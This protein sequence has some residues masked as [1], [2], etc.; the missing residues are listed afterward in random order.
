MI[1]NLKKFEDE[2]KIFGESYG[3][4]ESHDNV[5]DDVSSV[6]HTFSPTSASLE[7]RITSKQRFKVKTKGTPPSPIA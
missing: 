1:K 7:A 3:S 2:D 6:N 4:E 5:S